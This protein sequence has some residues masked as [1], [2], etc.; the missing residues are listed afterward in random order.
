MPQVFFAA[1]L[2]AAM[3][4][5][6]KLPR[7]FE[8]F[9]P[10][11]ISLNYGF[12]LL[13]AYVLGG[14]F[15]KIKL[16][17][18]SGYIVA[19]IACGPFALG[20]IDS[21][22]AQQMRLIDD[23]ALTFIALTAG[24][25]LRLAHLR[26]RKRTIGCVIPSITLVVSCGTALVV[27]LLREVFPFTRGLA[28]V[29]VLAIG[30]LFGVIAVARSPTSAV[31]IIDECRA[32]GPFTETVFGVTVAMDS[33][34]ILL[35]ACVV[36]FGEATI[37]AAQGVDLAF[38]GTVLLELAT[39]VVTGIVIGKGVAHYIQTVERDLT[40]LLVVLS[41]LITEASHWMSHTLDANLG[42]V[43][44]LEPLLIAITAG[45]VVQ[46][47]TSAGERLSKSLHAVALPIFVIFFSMTG[48]TLD[49]GA[50]AGTW[51]LAL[52]FVA[53]RMGL[54]SSAGYLGCAVAGEGP[55]FKRLFGFGFYTQAGVSLGLTQEIVR[56]FPEWGPAAGSFL[57]AVITLNQIVGPAAFKFALDRVGESGRQD[58]GPAEG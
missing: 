5:V 56:R 40:I 20:F 48:V 17:R 52:L 32:K 6:E 42:V 30:L 54:T 47:F 45:F 12:L 46:N 21:D 49:L 57:V 8:A 37:S 43:F 29:E 53:V 28:A 35:F 7:G 16:P 41:F 36:S 39:S 26:A 10:A 33:L 34:V 31:A 18:I 4:L 3:W 25:E 19:G 22:L 50:L 27:W 1:G 44:H 11:R 58:G 9:E 15:S 38:V 23:L 51:A 14:I 55:A 13:E 2:L 24:A